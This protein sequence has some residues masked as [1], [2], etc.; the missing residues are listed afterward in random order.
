MQRRPVGGYILSSLRPQDEQRDNELHQHS[1]DNGVPV[2]LP[3][4]SRR[5]PQ[6][7]NTQH[8]A[9]QTN[10]P[11]GPSVALTLFTGK[12]SHDD[13]SNADSCTKGYTKLLGY[14]LDNWS[15]CMIPNPVH[16]L[17]DDRDWNIKEYDPER[18]GKPEQEWYDPV[19]RL[20][21]TRAM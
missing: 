20:S 13:H 5:S 4:V 3:P 1:H 8:Q 2:N 16:G 14:A 9:K 7:E 10:R 19:L 21:S 6:G 15:G 18:N 17:R 11:V 12:R